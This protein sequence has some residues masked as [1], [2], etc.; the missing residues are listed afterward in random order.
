SR[1]PPTWAPARRYQP[2]GDL[3]AAITRY[4]NDEPIVARPASAAYQFRMF[5]RRHKAVVASAA[6]I[7][8]VLIGA[9]IATGAQAAIATRE[10]D[11]AVR[12]EALAV[13]RTAEVM[14]ARDAE[15]ALHRLAADRLVEVER[16][17]ARAST[18]ARKAREI[19]AALRG[20]L[21]AADPA[22]ARGRDITI[23]E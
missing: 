11:R 13:S 4:L 7:L 6:S 10:R 15:A 5:A 23:K 1:K 18:E 17:Y 20:M 21:A 16:A 2:P 12:A 8:I 14:K 3:A 9:V 19:A 22:E